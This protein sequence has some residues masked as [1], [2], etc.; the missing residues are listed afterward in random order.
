L[1][2]TSSPASDLSAA[3]KLG[4]ALETAGSRAIPDTID[5]DAWPTGQDKTAGWPIEA[6][7]HLDAA[8]LRATRMPTS[9]FAFIAR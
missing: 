4:I 7:E 3:L 6:R 1:C 5:G 2:R 9:G 8:P